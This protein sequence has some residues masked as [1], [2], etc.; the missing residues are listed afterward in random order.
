[1]RFLVDENLPARMVASLLSRGAEVSYVPGSL[2][3]SAADDAL[4][5]VAAREDRILVTRD[6][7]FPLPLRP[8]PPGLIPHQ[9]AS[10]LKRSNSSPRD[11]N[12]A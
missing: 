6:L 2:L 7:D 12:A 9:S 10:A 3:A 4:W 11:W 5:E 8:R 1:M